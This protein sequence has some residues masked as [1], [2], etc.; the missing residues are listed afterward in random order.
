MVRLKFE[1]KER[2]DWD[3]MGWDDGACKLGWRISLGDRT[4]AS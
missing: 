3:G 4:K 1:G 2:L